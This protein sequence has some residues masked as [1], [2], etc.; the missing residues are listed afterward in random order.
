MSILLKE[1]IT[2]IISNEIKNKDIT[3][4][5][6]D[7]YLL[8][9]DEFK[10][11]L[12]EVMQKRKERKLEYLNSTNLLGL[13]SQTWGL[14][15]RSVIHGKIFVT[16]L[17]VIRDMEFGNVYNVSSYFIHR[18]KQFHGNLPKKSSN[19]LTKEEFLALE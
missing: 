15:T 4:I 8:I 16:C 1:K 14:N 7:Y 3:N 11:E 18:G 5:I 10:M 6:M 17:V 19:R 13:Y 12:E 9:S 2:N